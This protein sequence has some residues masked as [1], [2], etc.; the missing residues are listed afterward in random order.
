[1]GT[2]INILSISHS[3]VLLNRCLEVV[4][5]PNNMVKNYQMM[6]K[7]KVEELLFLL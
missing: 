4:I 7:T 2:P 6:W 3:G 5:C 1:M